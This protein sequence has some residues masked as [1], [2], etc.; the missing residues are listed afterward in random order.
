MP[1]ANDMDL[2]REYAAR[3]SEPAFETL[4][5]RHVSLV[6]SVALRQVGNPAQAE[7]I[8]QAVFL[9]LA[10]K[11][12]RLRPDTILPGWLHETARFASASFLRGELRRHHREQEAYVQS[13]L[14]ES[15]A[16]PAWEQ[17]A[18]LLDEAIGQLGK[19]DRNAVV[20]RFFQNKSAREIAAA[21]NVHESAAQKRLNRAVEKLRA[22]FLKRGVAVSA[23]A[24]TG[25]LL[26]NSIPGVP[27]HL[28]A[29]VMAVSAKGTAVSSST[30]TLI[31]GA[32]KI[33]ALTKAK[34]AVV[35]GA[36][37]LLTGGITTLV[38][39]KVV[40]KNSWADNPKYWETDSRVLGKVPA[41]VF[42]FRPTRFTNGG[43]GV[44]AGDRMVAKNYSVG[45]LV[46][47]T[48][49][50]SQVRTVFPPDMPRE[51]F[52]VMSTMTGGSTTLVKNE[53]QKRFR[54]TAHP[55]TRDT[56]VLLLKVQNPN[57]PGLKPH[58]GNDGNSSSMGGNGIIKIQNQQLSGFVGGTIESRVGVPVLDETGL[59]G[60]YDLQL[61]WKSG[62][63]ESDKDAF[64][65]AVR[66]QLG[67]EL[68]PAT[69]PIKMLVVEKVK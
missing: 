25:A 18:P 56:D 66:D 29:S 26:V 47:N 11:A 13:K 39:D 60:H 31:K 68:V 34:S 7:E 24:L 55:E 17:L 61:Q 40:Y 38:V 33:M 48:Y 67:L 36:A 12:A 53:L 21:L 2:V 5:R 49:G 65:R 1:D 6:Y 59:T 10:R 35:I 20:L 64:V 28:A 37:V 3:N 57:P 63:G 4:V 45:D 27:G 50:F 43:G 8:T 16:D 14:Q 51:H 58:V 22:W 15:T 46:D 19:A 54:L 44:W 52:D 42:I 30:L 9:I 41:G 62:P 32:L 23:D 69:R